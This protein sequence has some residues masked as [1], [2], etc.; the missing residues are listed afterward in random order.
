MKKIIF[1]IIVAFSFTSCKQSTTEK[2]DELKLKKLEIDTYNKM[3]GDTM[4]VYVSADSVSIKHKIYTP[5]EI[6]EH[7]RLHD[8]IHVAIFGK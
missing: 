2:L 5:Q 1:V 8:S 7:K 3:L 4:Q 6:L